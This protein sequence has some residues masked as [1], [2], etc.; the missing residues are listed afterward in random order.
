MGFHCYY[1]CY[2]AFKRKMSKKK[3]NEGGG[4]TKAPRFA[5]TILFIMHTGTP[6]GR[7]K[8]QAG[9]QRSERRDGGVVDP[10]EEQ[11]GF[12]ETTRMMDM[13]E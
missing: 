7:R 9:G 5:L 2:T 13:K 1:R 4:V 8:K 6:C 3:T 11:Q 10:R 12:K